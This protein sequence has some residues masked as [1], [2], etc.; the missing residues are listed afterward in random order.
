MTEKPRGKGATDLVTFGLNYDVKPGHN[1]EFER[2][3]RESLELMKTVEGHRETRLYRDV[4]NPNSYLIYSDWEN[5]EA[6]SA[7]IRSDAFKQV[8]KLG[9]EILAAPPRHNVYTKG[10]MGGSEA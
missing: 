4:N 2:V 9:R 10:P 1:E 8:Q 6:F 5:K 7:F 3:T